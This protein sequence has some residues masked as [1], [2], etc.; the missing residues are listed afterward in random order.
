MQR[1]EWLLSIVKRNRIFRHRGTS[2]RKR[3]DSF[4]LYL[5]GLSY[6]DI[7]YNTSYVDV[8]HEAVRKWVKKIEICII[9]IKPQKKHRDTV[10]VDETKVKVNP[11]FCMECYRYKDKRITCIQGIKQEAS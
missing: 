1:Q 5:A 4:F 7:A 10:A 8:S 3:V 11:T 2:F 6:R 9:A